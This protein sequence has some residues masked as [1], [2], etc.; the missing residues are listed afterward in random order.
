MADDK[1]KIGRNTK[2]AISPKNSTYR[3]AMLGTLSRGS[4]TIAKCSNGKPETDEIK[5][6]PSAND[7]TKRA[8]ANE[9]YFALSNLGA[10]DDLLAIFG[11]WSDSLDDAR[12]LDDLRAFNRNGTMFSNVI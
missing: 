9:T 8:I 5:I 6:P 10:A 1:S 4:V 11:S 3:R 2:S 7:L 12:T